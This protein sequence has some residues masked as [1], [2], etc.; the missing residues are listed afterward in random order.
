M[1][2][3]SASRFSATAWARATKTGSVNTVPAKTTESGSFFTNA[4]EVDAVA[5]SEDESFGTKSVAASI[6][7][8]TVLTMAALEACAVGVDVRDDLAGD[9]EEERGWR[10][11]GLLKNF[12][13]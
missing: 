13:D 6:W 8:G 7:I 1:A 9:A 3:L 10:T 5:F 12:T 4:D 2:V 11:S